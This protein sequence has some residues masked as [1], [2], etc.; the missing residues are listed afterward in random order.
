[1]STAETDR[2]VSIVV[3]TWTEIVPGLRRGFTALEN[4]IIE[5][6][7]IDELPIDKLTRSFNKELGATRLAATLA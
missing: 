4:R 1:M 3:Q 5:C 7:L 2:R 6:S